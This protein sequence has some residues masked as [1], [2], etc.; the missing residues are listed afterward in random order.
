MSMTDN[1]L[2]IMAES[3]QKKLDILALIIQKNQEQNDILKQNEVD[4]DAF[5]AN[6]EAKAALIDRL[7]EL[8]HGFEAL[9]SRVKEAM[10]SDKEKYKDDIV[11]M[12]RLIANITDASITIQKGEA[13]NKLLAERQFSNMKKDIHEARRS[14]TMANKYYKAMSNVDSEP[15]FMDKKK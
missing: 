11:N 12:K 5:Q 3:L 2:V 8:D 14:T 9:F 10:E 13:D 15:Q 7:D 6:M 4:A 1:Y